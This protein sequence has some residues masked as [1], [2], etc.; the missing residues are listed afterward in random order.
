LLYNSVGA[1]S[2][3]SLNRAE[4]VY[5]T[6]R[7][8]QLQHPAAKVA[9]EKR[10]EPKIPAPT[11]PA[12]FDEKYLR[13][14]H[15]YLFQDV[16]PW[17]GETRADRNFQGLKKAQHA[18][19]YQTYAH[20]RQISPN[21]DAIS[22][23]LAQENNLK[24]LDREQFAKRAAYYM[25]HYNHVHAFREG[26]GRT[27]QAA[28]FELGRQ[29]GYKLNLTPELREFNPARDTAIVGAS[30]NPR[31]NIGQ[32]E[33]LLLR[34]V[35]PLRGKEAAEAR[36]PI[37]AR[38]LSEP[39]PE[40]ARIE[41]LRELKASSQAINIRLNEVRDP[42]KYDNFFFNLQYHIMRAPENIGRYAK[43]LHNHATE[44]AT[45]PGKISN[46]QTQLDRYTRAIDQTVQLYK[47][48][49]QQQVSTP[50]VKEQ[51][52]E[53][54]NPVPEVGIEKAPEPKQR[55]LKM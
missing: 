55:G 24:G 17:A 39:T 43:A 8:H 47:G 15:S 42:R 36:N 6:Q 1:E 25:D 30:A 11:I 32:L 16:Y 37:N 10:L 12:V 49:G 27:V 40:V 2:K 21:L 41:A 29:A 18:G 28:F 34:Q 35:E 48:Q 52:G 19:Y 14:M 7:L 53:K 46:G 4:A 33:S 5:F 22:K 44:A 26:N 20:Y 23:Q 38:P 54:A 13:H 50:T 3:D 45:S 31:N 51:K 9:P